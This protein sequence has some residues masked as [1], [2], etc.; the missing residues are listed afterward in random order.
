MQE[1]FKTFTVLISKINRLIRKIKTEEMVEF[2]LKSTHVSCLY[3]LYESEG[4]TSSGLT[5]I[6]QEDKALV[7]RALEQLE[8]G[9]FV[10]CDAEYKKRY[11]SRLHLTPRGERMG[12]IIASKIDEFFVLV[13]E[14]LEDEDR[15]A[16][17]RSLNKICDNLENICKIYEGEVKNER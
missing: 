9:G 7:S 8:E 17:Y 3:Y 1:R 13:G 5:D 12:R 16:M 14:G 4:L 11:R 15:D 10:S 2:D 6:T